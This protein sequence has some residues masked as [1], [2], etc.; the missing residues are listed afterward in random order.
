MKEKSSLFNGAVYNTNLR[1]YGF[2]FIL[3]FFIT[4]LL[5]DYFY[6]GMSLRF[7]YADSTISEL[8]TYFMPS[9]LRG[10]GQYYIFTLTP[11]AVVMGVVLFD[12]L[13]KEKALTTLHAMPVSRKSLYFTN[14]IAFISATAFTLFLN[15]VFMSAHLAYYHL[16]I[17]K[18]LGFLSQLFL[19]ELLLATAVFAFTVF[20]GMLVNNFIIQIGLVMVFFGAPVIIYQLGSQLFQYLLIGF[21]VMREGVS[22]DIKITPYYFLADLIF[23]YADQAHHWANNSISSGET[24]LISLILTVLL[25]V[26]SLVAG[27]FLYMKKDL[28]SCHELIATK[29]AKA[30]ITVLIAIILALVFANI[31][32]IFAISEAAGKAGIYIGAFVGAILGYLIMK[33]IAEKSLNPIKFIPKGLIFTAAILLVILAVDLD[34]FGYSNRVPEPEEVEYAYIYKNDWQ[35]FDLEK[36][37]HFYADSALARTEFDSRNIAKL[38]GDDVAKL[39]EVH[40]RL[41]LETREEE[42]N[43]RYGTQVCYVLKNGKV[44]NR[45]YVDLEQVDDAWMD[46]F[47]ELRES[48][49]NIEFLRA[50]TEKFV[51]TYIKSAREMVAANLAK[52]YFRGTFNDEYIIVSIDE[53]ESLMRVYALDRVD[54]LNNENINFHSYIDMMEFGVG[55]KQEFFVMPEFKRTL[56]WLEAHGYGYMTRP[57]VDGEMENINIFSLRHGDR[58]LEYSIEDKE[59][60]DNMLA[61][62]MKWDRRHGIPDSVEG[63]EITVEG[64]IVSIEIKYSNGEIKVYDMNINVINDIGRHMY[65]YINE[66][67]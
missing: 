22:L 15:F 32:G 62:I 33:M 29:R 64:P 25:L 17:A 41:I 12:Y 58:H 34:V 57:A 40:R 63:E 1:R 5:M 35:R 49:S 7:D 61:Y 16:E 19:L 54:A 3:Y 53:L 52:P 14:Y 4:E 23:S 55:D 47:A 28:E 59:M 56:D 13:K 51:D 37:E 10:V 31:I 24:W 66:E 43:D 46:T 11:L 21:T 6:I 26:V 8:N 18:V 50:D 2:V 9:L 48:P 60:M 65:S 38:A 42:V 45:S 44:I 30:V 27:Y 36:L 39:N 20:M 67:F